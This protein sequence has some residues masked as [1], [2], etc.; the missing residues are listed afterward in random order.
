MEFGWSLA[1]FGLVVGW[2]L[3][4][5]WMEFGSNVDG[6]WLEFGQNFC[7]NL[8][9]LLLEFWQN[10]DVAGI[11]LEFGWI[12]VWDIGWKFAII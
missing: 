4:E 8:A 2:N 3:A 6:V 7:G 1:G 11:C 10:L 9:G 12:L 5:N